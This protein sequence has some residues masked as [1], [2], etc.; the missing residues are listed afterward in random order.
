MAINR[1]AFI[2]NYL[3]ETGENVRLIDDGILK[4]KKDPE[5]EEVLNAVLRALH[6]IK[7]SSRMLK[8]GSMEKLSHAMENVFKGLKEKR[9]SI[10][11]DVVKLVFVSGDLF[12]MG[13]AKIEKEKD[14]SLDID[15]FVDVCE[16]AYANE[17]YG[18]ELVKL[19]G[20]IRGGKAEP[21]SRHRPAEAE[22]AAAADAFGAGQEKSEKKNGG[23]AP[24]SASPSDSSEVPEYQ[25]IRVKLSNV[26]RII[27]IL[28]GV[29]I[30]QFQFKQIQ[31]ELSEAEK[32]YQF[33]LARMRKLQGS[34]KEEGTGLY[35]DGLQHL[36]TLQELRKSFSDQMVSLEQSSYTLQEHIMKLSMLPLD[37][38]LG[39]LP[40]MVEE[41]AIVLGKEIDFSA[42]GSDVLMDK[43]ILE[44][45]NDPV[46]HLIRNS[47]DHGIEMPEERETQGK[48]RAGRIGVECTSEGGNIILRIR[49]DGAGIDPEKIMRQALEKGLT[50]EAELEEIGETEVYN[51][52]FMSGFSTKKTISDLSGRGVGLDIVKHNIDS[53]KGKI[54]IRSTKGEG[55]EFILSLPLS[56]ATVSGFFVRSG[57]EKF[58]IPSNFV[59]KIVRLHRGDKIMYFNKEAFK[60]ENHIVPLYSLSALLEKPPENRSEHLY[61]L[62]VESVGERIGIEVD[63]LLQHASLIYKPVPKNLQKM[64][65]IQGIVFDETY[66]I[67]NILFIPELINRFK[68]LKSIDLMQS[69]VD[70]EITGKKVMVVDDSLNTREIEK[71]IL[72][73][74]DYKVVTAGDGIEGLQLLKESK[75]DLIITDLEMPRMDGLTMIEN[76]RKE[77]A[78]R[79]LPIVVVSS[80]TDEKLRKRAIKAGADAYIVKSEFDRNSL[81]ATADELLKKG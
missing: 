80:S 8:F 43:A 71:S 35:R 73:L 17:S 25:S 23:S 7:G 75:V 19:Q 1:D 21:V 64:K 57:G 63:S 81:V 77:S 66:S 62:V 13:I 69:S 12:R 50:N 79:T 41:A 74:E 59:M 6:T 15:K 42:K 58:L 33:L 53:V 11:A 46:L 37:L 27:E 10:E 18:E 20:E 40:R 76:I 52:I 31:E 54:S 47:V 32:E 26:E 70:G 9:Y 36:K 38:I 65:L 51:F 55:T 39:G 5:N 30:K 60:L 22:S 16:R 49:D 14:D 28:N 29:I 68:R 44:K 48:P 45:I 78:Y 56:L 61:V 4:L 2:G 24:S 34:L 67:I 72:E 3:E